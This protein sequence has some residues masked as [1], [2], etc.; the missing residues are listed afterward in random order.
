[1]TLWLPAPTPKRD[2]WKTVA[3]LRTPAAS[4]DRLTP[5]ISSQSTANRLEDSDFHQL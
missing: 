1:M 4:A 2:G 5:H 3:D